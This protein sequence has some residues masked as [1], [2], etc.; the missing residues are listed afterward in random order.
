MSNYQFAKIYKITSKQTHKIY[1]GSTI[2]TLQT[3]L[4]EHKRDYK[5]YLRK[6]RGRTSSCE[7]IIYDDCIIELIENYPC[8]NKKELSMREGYYILNTEHTVNKQIPG[9]TKKEYTERNKDKIKER[10][11]VYYYSEKNII[12]TKERY[13]KNK[14]KI[15]DYRLEY[16][17]KN[18]LDINKSVRLR[19]AYQKTFGGRTDRDDNN[20]LLKISMDLFK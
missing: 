10:S 3:R 12:R 2:Q 7:I 5:Q 11:K 6:K 4:S 13:E 20:S 17:L 8:N 9:Q 1:I 19:R 15:K 18:R 14:E 16:Q